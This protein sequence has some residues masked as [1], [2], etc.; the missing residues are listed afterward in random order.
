MYPNAILG[1][2]I[3]EPTPRVIV[4]VALGISLQFVGVNP[5]RYPELAGLSFEHWILTTP[6]AVTS[7]NIGQKDALTHWLESIAGPVA[8]AVSGAL[9]ICTGKNLIFPFSIRLNPLLL[10]QNGR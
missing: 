10:L 5:L 6:A 3:T 9:R 8:L 1:I 4:L 2:R 7:P